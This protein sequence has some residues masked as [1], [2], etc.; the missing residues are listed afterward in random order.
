MEQVANARFMRALTNTPSAICRA[1]TGIAR[2][3]RSTDRDAD[4]ARKIFAAIGVAVE[5]DEAQ[6]DIVTA[7]SG[8]GPAFIYRVVEALAEG[9][10]KLGLSK[11]VALDL[12]V[13]TAR[14]AADLMMETGMSP[15]E[16]VRMVVTPGGTTAAG[17]DVMKKLGTKESLISAIEA[18]SRRGEEMAREFGS[19]H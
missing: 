11:K 13:Q 2:G 9:G 19:D 18:A 17:L 5:V 15:D 7:L 14:G 12:A 6:I 1:A 8:S 4:V 16:L 10:A 3:S